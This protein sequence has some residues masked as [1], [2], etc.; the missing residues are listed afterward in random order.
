MNNCHSVYCSHTLSFIVFLNSTWEAFTAIQHPR[1]CIIEL[2]SC[3][4]HTNLF[5]MVLS[6][7]VKRCSSVADDSQSSLYLNAVSPEAETQ[8]QHSSWRIRRP[9]ERWEN[10]FFASF[11]CLSS[12]L[13][14]NFFV[15]FLK[16]ICSRKVLSTRILKI[17]GE[18][19][20]RGRSLNTL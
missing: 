3:S 20:D 8:E 12:Q 7:N 16:Q 17:S 10:N 18:S 4:H 15:L 19:V 14:H 9:R 5:V 2:L 11:V 1:D 13:L 6:S